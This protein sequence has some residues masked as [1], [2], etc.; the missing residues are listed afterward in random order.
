MYWASVSLMSL[1]DDR[2]EKDVFT[3]LFCRIKSL[4]DFLELASGTLT[5]NLASAQAVRIMI[6]TFCTE[7]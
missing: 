1:G 6:V 7:Q 2:T 4:L 5:F 3:I